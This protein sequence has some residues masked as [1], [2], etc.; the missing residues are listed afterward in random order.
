MKVKPEKM[1]Q[2]GE[3]ITRCDVARMLGNGPE[4]ERADAVMAGLITACAILLPPSQWDA[5]EAQCELDGDRLAD[6][7]ALVPGSTT[8]DPNPV[9]EV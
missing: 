4:A 6:L 5:L 8:P 3:I 9:L 2:L 1:L 7:A